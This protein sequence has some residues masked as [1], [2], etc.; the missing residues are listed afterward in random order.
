MIFSSPLSSQGFSIGTLQNTI[1]WFAY[2]L[3]LGCAGILIIASVLYMAIKSKFSE[4]IIFFLSII[5][6][7]M[8]FE[9]LYSI[10]YPL[11]VATTHDR[12]FYVMFI[13]VPIVAAWIVPK[14]FVKIVK[15]K[16]PESTF[17]K[18]GRTLLASIFL[19]AIILVGSLS[20][21]V[22]S[23]YWAIASG[24]TGL[25]QNT[26]PQDITALNYL[27]INSPS[28][29]T[30]V[31]NVGDN[32]IQ[33]FVAALASVQ[34]LDL[35]QFNTWFGTTQ[36]EVL[37]A[38]KNLLNVTY[39]YLSSE[40]LADISRI[41]P[42][43]Y[44]INHLIKYLPKIDFPFS[45]VSIYEMPQL[46]PS[47]GNNLSVVVPTKID[48]STFFS[49]ETIA[50]SG[51]QYGLTSQQ[52]SSKFESKTII[53]PFDPTNFEALGN[54]IIISNGNQST[55]WTPT[56]WDSGSISVPL[57]SNESSIQDKIEYQSILV[58]NG[59][60]GKWGI[61]HDYPIASDWSNKDTF[62]FYWK[63][64]NS[65][66]S[67]TIEIRTPDISNQNVY[68]FKD[69][70]IG[71]KEMLVPISD[72]NNLESGTFDSSKVGRIFIYPDASGISGTYSIGP[73][74]V[75]KMS[76]SLTLS[77]IQEYTTWLNNGGHIVV[78]DNSGAGFFGDM[79]GLKTIGT[80]K[81]DSIVNNEKSIS[82]GEI[83]LP[84]LK[85]ENENATVIGNYAINGQYV[86]PFS[87]NLPIGKGQV[88]YLMI[89]P[90]YDSL[91]NNS[92]TLKTL[93]FSNTNFLSFLNI[94]NAY[95][96]PQTNYQTLSPTRI[97]ISTANGNFSG[98]IVINSSSFEIGKIR[99]DRID[100]KSVNP[101]FEVRK[102]YVL[103]SNSLQ[104]AT[105]LGFTISGQSALR[106]ESTK[107]YVEKQRIFPENLSSF[108]PISFPNGYDMELTIPANT[109][110][111]INLEVN[112]SLMDVAIDS[113][114]VSAKTLDSSS[115][116]FKDPLIIINGNAS[117]DKAW[118]RR[119]YAVYQKFVDHGSLIELSGTTSFEIPLSEKDKLYLSDFK[120]EGTYTV[121][122]EDLNS[123]IAL[124]FSYDAWQIN[125][126]QILFSP[127]NIFLMVNIL[128]I[129]Y[130]IFQYL[131]MKD[132]NKKFDNRDN[133]K[134]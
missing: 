122:Q 100:L 127:S 78:F 66:T 121:F 46:Y 128:L 105:L 14:I 57:I 94:S 4:P 93:L 65:G 61:Y 95:Y 90:Y 33:N 104:N 117:F 45:N 97:G 83:N 70:F 7:S 15:S 1:P 91:A 99:F 22:S 87:I 19:V 31:T 112:N 103:A 74:F 58:Q 5:G 111:I 51:L 79:F 114:T 102:N 49:I 126:S 81:A 56:S 132:N 115:S 67:F 48:D 92:E 124:F 42:Q 36:P 69:N 47:S 73:M 59:A 8:I 27:K 37:F 6:F 39:V 30:V 71:W 43:S 11:S 54:N 72:F 16:L 75:S 24:P 25:P 84:K 123:R 3:R 108:I 17:R 26:M 41:Y 89:K 62:C 133:K 34:T 129:S 120:F 18:S 40:D 29:S 101:I 110:A 60:A 85:V 20:T 88:T 134:D 53:L 52:Y 2:S 21:I 55:F 32:S 119:P 80:G 35:D 82:T 107:A 44:F 76:N 86:S 118:F 63:G 23:E 10:L 9:R 98:N 68:T 106:I 64:T 130:I 113:G 38:M 28:F 131:K 50:S 96:S 77:Q 12:I 125:L 109:S 116:L 13:A